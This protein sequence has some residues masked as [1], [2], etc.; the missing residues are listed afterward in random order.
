MA[1][2]VAETADKDKDSLRNDEFF[3]GR[4][5]HCLRIVGGNREWH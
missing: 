2:K 1:V 4:V 5:L 3:F